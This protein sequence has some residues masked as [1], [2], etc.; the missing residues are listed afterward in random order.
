MT[1][2]PDV[3]VVG[4]GP[5]GLTAA[6]QAAAHGADVRVVEQRVDP[7]RPSRA[8]VLHSRALEAL[9]PLGVTEALLE[10]ADT[11]PR[12]CLH[13]GDRVVP[14]RLGRA[15]LPGTPYPH[16][17]LVR[18][19]DVEEVLV[20]ALARRGVAVE[21]GVELVDAAIEP[22]RARVVLR[23]GR[24]DGR[25]TARWLV[26]CDGPDSRVRRA[27]GIGWRGG[28]YREEVVLADVE[29]DGD[30]EPGAL[31]VAAGRPGLL[32]LFALGEG[33]TWRVLGTRPAQEGSSPFG[34]PGDPVPR[35]QVQQ[36]L[37]GS[38]VHARITSLAWSARVAMQHRRAD[39]FRRGPL[40]LAGD[41]AHTH[42]PAAAQ[43]MNSGILDAVNLGWKLALA[44]AHDAPGPLL[45]SYD[46][47]RR[48]VA[49]QVLALTHAV[50]LAEAS[51]HPVPA[52][53]RGSLVPRT[54]PLLPRLAGNPHLVGAVL[55]VLSQRWV[56]HRRSPLSVTDGS[57]SRLARGA[58]PGDRLPDRE[59]WCRGRPVRLHELTAHPGVHLLLD[60][61][62]TDVPD[63]LRGTT[64]TTH[65]VDSWP[66]RGVLAVRPDGIV[67]Y[68]SEDAAAPGL[69]DWLHL[70][71]AV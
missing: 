58:R 61:C 68:R 38:G 15:A 17:T 37:E 13:L 24:G 39:A 25:A 42:S 10:R 5:T 12:A 46:L 65:H 56:R 1:A 67:G 36:L 31:H 34:Q 40:F 7:R 35:E 70:V 71:G 26:G 59:V 50:F 53:L 44:R 60:R 47:E 20:G 23:T 64:V 51:T 6:L 32:F 41:A 16:L 54:A 33:A 4:A 18:Q 48:P 57:V 2:H 9:R 22:D 19:S 8:M 11:D 55:A 28:P 3:L 27:A 49:G 21:R 63:P 29:L 45:D 43:G 69:R 14:V 66:G 62:A 30:L 52:A